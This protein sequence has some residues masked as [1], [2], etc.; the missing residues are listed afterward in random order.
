METLRR[1]ERLKAKADLTTCG[2]IK[3][4]RGAA[5]NPRPN[6]F[7]NFLKDF[8]P[9]CKTGIKSKNVFKLAGKKWRQMSAEE[10]LKYKN[11]TEEHL[12]ARTSNDENTE[13][14]DENLKSIVL[15][16]QEDGK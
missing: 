15:P 6:P 14:K 8:R 11:V 3:K 12:D 16:K 1:S 10:K 2:A 7:I 5:K 4:K 13:G 9:L